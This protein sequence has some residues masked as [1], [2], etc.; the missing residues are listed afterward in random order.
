MRLLS[1]LA[2]LLF[3][4][5]ITGMALMLFGAEIGWLMTPHGNESGPL[6]WRLTF[7]AIT[8]FGTPV[9]ALSCALRAWRAPR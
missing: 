6:W 7:T 9:F 8:L 3:V 2:A 1:A 4:G 5:F